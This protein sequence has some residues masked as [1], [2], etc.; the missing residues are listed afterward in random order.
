[1]KR[2]I[3]ADGRAEILVYPRSVAYLSHDYDCLLNLVL[4]L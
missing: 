3:A 2:A 4:L 1:V